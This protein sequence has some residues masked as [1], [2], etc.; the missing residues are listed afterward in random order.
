MKFYTGEQVQLIYGF[1]LWFPTFVCVCATLVI[2]FTF[3]RQMLI[4]CLFS[5][6]ILTHFITFILQTSTSASRSLSNFFKICLLL[7][8]L[9]VYIQEQ[10]F[11][12]HILF[13]LTGLIIFWKILRIGVCEVWLNFFAYLLCSLFI[14][15]CILRNIFKIS[16][17]FYKLTMIV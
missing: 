1:L 16:N 7:Y 4:Q 12:G 8:F 6:V 15:Y 17:F 9:F 11:S 10:K 2:S 14:I 5:P 3:W 13:S